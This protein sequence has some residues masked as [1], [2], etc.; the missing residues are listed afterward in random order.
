MEG[1][2][3]ACEPAGGE[4]V[5]EGEMKL[6]TLGVQSVLLLNHFDSI[7]LGSFQKSFSCVFYRFLSHSYILFSL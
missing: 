2:F 3:F 4:P 1:S 5:Q 6:L 7:A